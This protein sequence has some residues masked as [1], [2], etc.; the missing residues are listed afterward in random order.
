MISDQYI[1]QFFWA[2]FF[3]ANKSLAI[4]VN[5]RLMIIERG[6]T[7]AGRVIKIVGMIFMVLYIMARFPVPLVV[8]PLIGMTAIWVSNEVE[9]IKDERHKKKNTQRDQEVTNN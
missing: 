1:A 8:I 6:D 5:R 9:E 3:F 7:L 4:M 2:I